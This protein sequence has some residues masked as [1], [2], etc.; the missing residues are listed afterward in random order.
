MGGMAPHSPASVA[1]SAAPVGVHSSRVPPVVTG[2]PLPDR[3]AR[4]AGT[5]TG[6]GPWAVWTDPDPSATAPTTTRESGRSRPSDSSAAAQPTT[7]ASESSAPTSWRWTSE[8]SMPWTWA[9]ALP[10]RVNTEVAKAVAAGDRPARAT[11]SRI[12][13]SVREAAVSWTSTTA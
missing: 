11:N 6:S 4:T 2:A 13:G 5:G 3:M 10:S 8:A 1:S 9:S 7:S 12:S